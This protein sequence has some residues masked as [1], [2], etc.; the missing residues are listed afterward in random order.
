[1]E[2][3]WFTYILIC[4]IN[5]AF[6][7]LE[8]VTRTMNA[9][10]FIILTIIIS[11]LYIGVFPL[12]LLTLKGEGLLTGTDATIKTMRLVYYPSIVSFL[13]LVLMFVISERK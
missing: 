5:V 3:F 2:Q 6:D 9:K 7:I 4:I 11:I 8:I 13:F 10:M 1:M 12:L